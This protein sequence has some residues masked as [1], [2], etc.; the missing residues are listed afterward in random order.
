[1]FVSSLIACTT[2]AATIQRMHA[3]LARPVMTRT[4]TC[5]K[6]SR[7]MMRSARFA[8]HPSTLRELCL[9][10][11]AKEQSP[12]RAPQERRAKHAL[13]RKSDALVAICRSEEHT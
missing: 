13:S 12:I 5:K 8:I 3:L 10:H 2:A 6:T 9:E 11:K 7:L 4:Q 1:M